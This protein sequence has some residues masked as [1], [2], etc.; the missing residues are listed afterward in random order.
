[1]WAAEIPQPGHLLEQ[2]PFM[3]PCLRGAIVAFRLGCRRRSFA[4][5][6]TPQLHAGPEAPVLQLDVGT[7]VE[8]EASAAADAER[9]ACAVRM[10]VTVN[11]HGDEQAGMHGTNMLLKEG[12]FEAWAAAVR[13]RGGGAHLRVEIANPRAS[14]ANKRFLDSNLNRLFQEDR[15]DPDTPGVHGYEGSIVGPIAAEIKASTHYLDIHTCSALAPPCALPAGH[16]ASEALAERLPVAFVVQDLAHGTNQK[17]TSMDWCLE[18]G[19]VGV[20]LECGQHTDPTSVASAAACIRAFVEAVSGIPAGAR[21]GAAAEA[22]DE[23]TEGKA[24]GAAAAASGSD[25]GAGAAAGAGAEV[26]ASSPAAAAAGPP[27]VLRCV[28]SEPVRRGFKWTQ[29]VEAF[30]AVR[31]EAVIAVDEEVG[32]LTISRCRDDAPA[33]WSRSRAEP[34]AAEADATSGA[35]PSAGGGDGGGD[36]SGEES[37]DPFALWYAVMPTRSAVEREEAWFSCIRVA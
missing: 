8:L 1:M 37:K 18:H 4:M 16:D 14:E 11:V 33:D 17:G 34:T 5:M 31:P 36:G 19:V 30:Q 7:R 20:G 3:L 26:A 13:E 28:G 12:W 25:T 27:V 9:R 35:A 32:E 24:D 10:Y 29:R 15:I 23:A 22:A 2:T 6:S 21:A